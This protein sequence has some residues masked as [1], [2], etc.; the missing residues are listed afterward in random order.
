MPEL[1]A[2]HRH[3]V[4]SAF[5]VTDSGRYVWNYRGIWPRSIGTNS[6][7]ACVSPSLRVLCFLYRTL[8]V[9]PGDY[10]L[11]AGFVHLGAGLACGSTGM[12]AGYA[13]GVVGDSVSVDLQTQRRNTDQ[14]LLVCSSLCARV[15]DFR[16]HGAHSHFCGSYRIVWVNRSSY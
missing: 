2:I 4:I 12:A 5:S 16:D 15:E 7:S 1:I 11:F 3:K 14:I 8:E 13:I 6:W 10:S 9:K